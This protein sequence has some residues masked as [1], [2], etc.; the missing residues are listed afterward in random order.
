MKNDW[1]LLMWCCWAATADWWFSLLAALAITR[2]VKKFVPRSLLNFIHHQF[3][4]AK[5]SVSPSSRCIPA[6][7]HCHSRLLHHTYSQPFTNIL[8]VFVHNIGIP[9]FSSL[10]KTLHSDTASRSTSIHNFNNS[11][12]VCFWFTLLLV[13]SLLVP[14]SL[15]SPRPNP[16]I[17]SNELQPILPSVIPF[18]LS[19]LVCLHSPR[20]LFV[21]PP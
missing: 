3:P 10:S 20:L 14:H 16:F 6:S 4:T 5:L 11:K 19:H 21:T 15:Q 8:I 17:R 12:T 13:P 1:S 7:I 2:T 18:R 9:T